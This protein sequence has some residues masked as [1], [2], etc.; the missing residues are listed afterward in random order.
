MAPAETM[1]F[2]R[3]TASTGAMMA[4]PLDPSMAVASVA[5]VSGRTEK[6]NIFFVYSMKATSLSIT[7][8]GDAPGISICPFYLWIF[9]VSSLPFLP[10]GH[11]SFCQSVPAL[12]PRWSFLPPL[13]NCRMIIS[14]MIFSVPRRLPGRLMA[15]APGKDICSGTL[16][17]SGQRR[18]KTVLLF[19][20]EGRGDRWMGRWIWGRFAQS[21]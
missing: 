15:S 2:S 7:C 11:F 16:G 13:Q 4:G 19:S 18:S 21:S 8:Q 14:T 3:S 9:S 6:K 1:A 10:D 5:R 20:K 12:P 17:K